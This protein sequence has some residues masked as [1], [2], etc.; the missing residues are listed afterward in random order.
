MEFLQ[1]A[2][3]DIN[4]FVWGPVMLVFLVG[5]GI[6]LTVRLK[7]LPWRN[8]G[9]SLKSLFSKDAFSKGDGPGDISPF[10]ALMTALAATV[11]TGNIVGVAT[12]M[13]LGGPGALVWMWISAA[14]GITTKFAE[15]ALSGK[16]R[17]VNEKGEMCGGPMYTLKY[18]MKNKKLGMV[19]AVMF[20]IFTLLASFGIGNSAQANSISSAVNSTFNIPKW[21]VGILL[22]VLVAVVVIGG[23]QSISKVTT[24][25]V[26]AM[27]GFYIICG[28][29][30]IIINAKNLPEE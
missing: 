24:I 21:V 26:P 10:S 17:T 2:L 20:S 1:K 7:F 19:L 18:G 6:F 25:F 23:I 30:V 12:A 4:N 3:Q 22:V 11:G 8:L 14:F 16:Y 13:V 15:C 9:N 27:A 28:L 5:T 29:I